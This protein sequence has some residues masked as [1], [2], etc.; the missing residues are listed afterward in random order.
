[1]AGAIHVVESCCFWWG[2]GGEKGGV[3]KIRGSDLIP[4]HVSEVSR[5]Q[6][7]PVDLIHG[8]SNLFSCFTQSRQKGKCHLF[9]GDAWAQLN[10][11][12]AWWV[13]HP[14]LQ[15]RLKSFHWLVDGPGSGQS[16]P[17]FET[18]FQ[19]HWLLSSNSNG[20]L[21]SSATSNSHSNAMGSRPARSLAWIFR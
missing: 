1:M 3:A 17:H 2:Q 16:S 5:R 13:T 6:R 7:C 20:S 4:S 14:V 18:N 8:I 11:K 10:C 19:S 12:L 21:R 15:G 9:L